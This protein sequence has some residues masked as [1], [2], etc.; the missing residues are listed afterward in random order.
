MVN[1]YRHRMRFIRGMARW[2]AAS[3]EAGT[4][5]L[6]TPGEA[7]RH[8]ISHLLPVEMKLAGGTDFGDSSLRMKGIHQRLTENDI[9]PR[10]VFGLILPLERLCFGRLAYRPTSIAGVEALEPEMSLP[11]ALPTDEMLSDTLRESA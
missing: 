2:G 7:A 8:F 11:S 5:T 1:H 9:T 3:P 4:W 6:E 10:R